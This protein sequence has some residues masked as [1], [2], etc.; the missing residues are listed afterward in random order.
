MCLE[1]LTLGGNYLKTRSMLPRITLYFVGQKR[2]VDTPCTISRGKHI[3]CWNVFIK[4]FPDWEVEGDKVPHEKQQ[5]LGG[6]RIQMQ[7]IKA[8]LPQRMPF[9]SFE[10][11]AFPNWWSDLQWLDRSAL[12]CYES[13]RPSVEIVLGSLNLFLFPSQWHNPILSGD[14]GK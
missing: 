14:A 10:L 1:L 11:K 6:R 9:P 3:G 8:H 2:L 13:D 7:T 4:K 5:G 12:Q